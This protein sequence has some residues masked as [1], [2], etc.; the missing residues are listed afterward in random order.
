MEGTVL[1]EAQFV[2]KASS[3]SRAVVLTVAL[4]P[5]GAVLL[6]NLEPWVPRAAIWVSRD[7]N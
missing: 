6:P 3:A 5:S 4:T 7:V 1:F 2:T